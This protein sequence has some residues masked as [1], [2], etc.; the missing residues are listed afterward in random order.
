MV[1]SSF[2]QNVLLFIDIFFLY[3]CKN[4]VLPFNK[5]TI[6]D[7]NGRKTIDDFLDYNLY[8]NLS[9]GTP[10]QKVSHFI[11]QNEY[12]FNFKKK[13]SL[14]YNFIKFSQFLNKENL[15]NFCFD[16][17]K[18]STFIINDD[19]EEAFKEIYYFYTLNNGIIKVENLSH[20]VEI[21]EPN[22]L[23]KCGVIGLYH[24]NKRR[25][26]NN[27]INLMEELKS[28]GI[29]N[30]Y[31]F[32]IL[33]KEKCN[34][35]DY[36]KDNLG[37]IIIGESPHIYNYTKYNKKEEVV[38]PEKNWSIIIN[39]LISSKI[40]YTEEN[41]EME[42][43]LNT[44][45]II[46]SNPYKDEIHIEFFSELIKKNLCK[47]ED[48]QENIFPINYYAY[49]CENNEEMRENI[50]LFPSLK[51]EIKINDL[52]FIFSYRDLFKLFNDKLYFM[53]I[54]K[55][56]KY[57]SNIPRWVMGEIFLRKYI[58]TFNYDSKMIIFYR[59]QVNE[60][61]IKR[62]YIE[63]TNSQK[64]ESSF[65]NNRTFIEI[66]MGIVIFLI[67]YLLVKRYRNKKKIYANELED[68][69][70]KNITKENQENNNLYKEFEMK[71]NNALIN[72]DSN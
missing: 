18:S 55:I 12:Y 36:H 24:K 33:Y 13:T 46:G 67:F 28:K 48:L 65:I 21:K 7:F 6:E 10:P 56:E 2:P 61:N 29:I 8:T 66:L 17:N 31:S 22:Y 59:N 64:D 27:S 42:I 69:N 68:S 38:N 20:N 50:K 34:L 60:A 11:L 71:N 26:R 58:T 63:E 39:R 52:Y 35:F 43:S 25:Y 16:N 9:M 72:F 41:I 45:F 30:E 23:N 70:Y 53:I 47:L 15:S 19:D 62:E 49:S 1:F 32:T 5:I 51:F 57:T 40:N 14:S 54:F 3:K 4:I 44:A 37:I